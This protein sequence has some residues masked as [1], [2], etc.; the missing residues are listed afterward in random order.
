MALFRR[1]SIKASIWRAEDTMVPAE[2]PE[3]RMCMLSTRFQVETS[4]I[5]RK[6]FLCLCSRCCCCCCAKSSFMSKWLEIFKS[7]HTQILNLSLV[8][9]FKQTNLFLFYRLHWCHDAVVIVRW[10]IHL[11]VR[12]ARASLASRFFSDSYIWNKILKT[13]WNS[14]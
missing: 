8:Q 4:K 1:Y 9:S 3:N 14:W 13:R 11:C 10:A 7:A 6:V 12:N 5:I 2:K